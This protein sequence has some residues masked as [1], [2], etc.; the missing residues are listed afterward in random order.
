MI[1]K[2]QPA[3]AAEALK[4]WRSADK[5][6]GDEDGGGGTYEELCADAHRAIE[7][8]KAESKSPEDLGIGV[9]EQHELI[10]QAVAHENAEARERDG[11]PPAE[12]PLEDDGMTDEVWRGNP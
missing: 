2:S 9:E 11:W 12:D 8:A 10:S 3:T 4:F 5:Y 7:L 6:Y 1:T